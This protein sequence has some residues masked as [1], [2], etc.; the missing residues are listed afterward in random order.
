PRLPPRPPSLPYPTLFRSRRRV[1]PDASSPPRQRRHRRLPESV[2]A[3]RSPPTH[4]KTCIL[5]VGRTREERTDRY[6]DRYT[7]GDAGVGIID[8]KSTRLNSS[9]VQ[10]SYA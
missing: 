3:R 4:G 8:R 2:G 9:H 7:V 6:R 5:L 10:T 1:T